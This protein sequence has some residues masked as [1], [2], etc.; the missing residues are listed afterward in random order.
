MTPRRPSAALAALA[1]LVVG[2]SGDRSLGLGS[3]VRAGGPVVVWDA[4][5]KPLPRIPLPND[6]ATRLD[7]GSPT[8]RRINVSLEATTQYERELRRLINRLDG[9]APFGTIL[10]S[11]DRPLDTAKLRERH[12]DD[13]FRNDAVFLLNVSPTCKRFGEEVALDIGRGRFPVTLNGHSVRRSDPQAPDGYRVDDSNNPFFEW[14]PNGE[15]N[16]ILFE[17]RNEDANGNGVLDPGEDTD[18]DGRLDFANFEDP[19]ACDA[20]APGST[21]RDRCIAD[22]LLTFYDREDDSLSLRNVWPLEEGCT[23]AVVLTNRLVGKDGKPVESPFPGMNPRDHTAA[24]RPAVAL[25]ERYG[26][27]LAD[28]AFAWTFTVARASLE[29]EVLRQGLYEHGPF[30]R[31]GREF[32]VDG[33]TPRPIAGT[34]K[35]MAGNLAPAGCSGE[36][37]T[38]IW[39]R[40]LGEFDANM[41]AL[42]GDNAATGG[43]F[44]GTFEAPNFLVDKDGL[45]TPAYPQDQDESWVLDPLTGEGSYGASTVT[46]WC[47]L[48]REKAEGC[49]PGNPEGRPFCRPFPVILYA[50]GYGSAR[51]E[52]TSHN[53]RTTAMGYATCAL[54]SYGH[55]INRALQFEPPRFGDTVARFGLPGFRD[56]LYTGRDR[57]LNNDSLTDPGADQWTANLFHTRDIV[58]QSALEYS[59]FVRILR[60]FDGSRRAKDGALLGDI[61]GDGRVDVGGPSNTV[62][63]WGIS[64]GGIVTGVLA[65]S[66]PGLDAVSPNAAAGGLP[67]VSVRSRQAGIGELVHLVTGGPVIGGFIPMDPHQ[68]PD[69]SQPMRIVL[70]VSDIRSGVALVEPKPVVATVPGVR[71]GDKVTVRNLVNGVSRTVT[72]TRRGYW[73]TAIPADA[74][75][76]IQRRP[77]LGLESDGDIGPRAPE[78]NTELG[79][80]LSIEIVDG[81]TGVRRALV[82][83]FESDW[84]FQG[85]LY[86][87]G[88]PLVAIQRG[89]GLRRNTPEYRRFLSIAQT[90]IAGGDPATWAARYHEEPLDT[91]YDPNHRPRRTRTL[92]MPTAGDFVV[93]VN[94][95]VALGRAAGFLGS[96]QRDESISAEHGWRRL[97]VP[98]PRYG[99]SVDQHLLDTYVV[100]GDT[101]YRRFV[102]DVHGI[103]VPYDVDDDSDGELRFTCDRRD[104][105]SASGETR[106]PAD[107]RDTEPETVFRVKNGG[108]GKALRMNLVRDDGR[109]DAF[110][111][112]VLR[113]H[114]QHGIYNAQPFR[115][116][117]AD[118]FSVNFT[119]R[120]LGTRGRVVSQPAGCD[121]TASRLPTDVLD[122]E[123]EFSALQT[124]AC[125]ADDLRL[126]DARCAAAWGIETPEVNTCESR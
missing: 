116:F 88:S 122:G 95:G 69:L 6:S 48:P 126:C 15:S 84:S 89:L 30:A 93:P 94:T 13:D 17:D 24:L 125:T 2:C 35:G 3:A 54:D 97:F 64:L 43:L 104:W 19:A 115:F 27:A 114:G 4:E 100:E 51:G 103:E 56:M 46:F 92:V 5:A 71:P 65:G 106:C 108:P 67:D 7:P 101:R 39:A 123:P 72:V 61:D 75:D 25:L 82:E 120:F 79:D 121:C 47:A 38:G 1:L 31:L 52:V 105:S 45:A 102:D 50:H 23:Y 85:T 98:D 34:A 70:F 78:D 113:P 66:E 96:W 77:I 76:P 83:T 90:V 59:Q 33:F 49:T 16:N 22:N 109:A 74:L 53:G 81:Q 10:V 41:C 68:N 86:K 55:G 107:L 58:R 57:D 60:S 80:A 40:V 63:A 32:P 99:K 14:D 62:S 36:A 20:L 119:L 37:L 12:A 29:L 9:F 110:R 91:S 11:F 111:V 26:V 118:A 44:W 21:E 18:E 73:R 112:P 42:Q 28:I 124:R 8:G 87:A 117:D